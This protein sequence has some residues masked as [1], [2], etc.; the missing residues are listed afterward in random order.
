VAISC[1]LGYKGLVLNGMFMLMLAGVLVFYKKKLGCIT[2]DMLGA[3]TEIMEAVLFLSAG[4][5]L[6]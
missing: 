1:F 4:A 5:G 3:L 2:G 6:I